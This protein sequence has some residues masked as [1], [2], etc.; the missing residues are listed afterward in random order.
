MITG[1]TEQ[2]LHHS[3][4]AQRRVLQV[5]PLAT[6]VV[7]LALGVAAC[8]GGS[9]NADSH[10]S[11]SVTSHSSDSPTTTA[12]SALTGGSQ[13][14]TDVTSKMLE[15]AQCMRSH[16]VSNFPDPSATPPSASPSGG[17]SYLG[18]SFDPNTPT[19]EAASAACAKYANASPVTPAGAA[20][21]LAE[22]LRYAQCMRAHGVPDFPDPSPSGGSDIPSSIDQNSSAFQAAQNA[23]KTL[24]PS[25]P[26]LPGSSGN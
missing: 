13:P 25:L 21:V 19:Y 12:P 16:G 22:Q 17:M 14:S 1:R 7:A 6:V 9:P 18:D 4:T 2:T 24:L 3:S 26:G 23:C 15:F 20:Q 8:G 10:S 11:N 5:A